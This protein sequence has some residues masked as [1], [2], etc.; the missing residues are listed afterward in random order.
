MHIEV[1]FFYAYLPN[2]QEKEK[3]INSLDVPKN[4][5]YIDEKNDSEKWND[6]IQKV[7]ENDRIHILSIN[8]FS[9]EEVDLRE[10]LEVLKEHHTQLLHMDHSKV[11]INLILDVMNFVEESKKN[12]AMRLQR[13]GIDKALEKKYKG[14]GNFG[15]PKTKIPTD[16][17]ENLERIANKEFTHEAYREMIGMKRSTYYKF[18]REVKDSLEKKN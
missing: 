6:L 17:S 11:D 7:R 5:I 4:N 13:V 18:V 15:R 12:R 9:Y 8:Q 1:D 10:K 16:F 3:I 14:E 2:L